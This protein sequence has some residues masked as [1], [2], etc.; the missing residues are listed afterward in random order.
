MSDIDIRNKQH[1]LDFWTALTPSTDPVSTMQ[2]FLTEDVELRLSHPI[3]YLHGIDT[4]SINFWNP[5][6]KALPDVRFE[7]YILMGNEWKGERWATSTGYFRG[8]FTNDWLGIP[9][10]GGEVTVRYGDFW[11]FNADGKMNFAVMMLDFIDL[12]QQVGIHVLRDDGGEQGYVPGPI[13]GDGLLMTP[14]NNAATLTSIQLVE[15]MIDGL[16]SFDG[17]TIES[18]HQSDFWDVENMIWYGPAPIGKAVGLR[19]FEAHHQIPFLA[20]FPDRV[21]GN[22]VARVGDGLYMATTGWPSIYATW[23]ADYLGVPNP[24]QRITMRVMDWWRREGDRLTENWVFIDI[25][26]LM[27]QVGFDVFANLPSTARG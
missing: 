22:H 16:L 9:A 6:K 21:G 19:G 27:Q 2:Q 7:P 14:Q 26:H 13:A 1:L 5:L 12:M 20:A 11:R 24:N 23:Q 17:E 8:T 25:P 4:V 10:N 3:N 18:M 15:A